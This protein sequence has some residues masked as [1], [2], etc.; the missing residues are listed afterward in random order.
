MSNPDRSSTS[1]YAR[2]IRR[3][4][5]WDRPAVLALL[6]GAAIYALFAVAV[7]KQAAQIFAR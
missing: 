5:A 1:S 4:L 6:A 2:V 3:S 7:L